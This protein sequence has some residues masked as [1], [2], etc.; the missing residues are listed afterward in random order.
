MTLRL[1]HEQES[2]DPN[3][4]H[5]QLLQT[6]LKVDYENQDAVRAIH[7]QYKFNKFMVGKWL[8]NLVLPE[9]LKQYSKSIMAS[10]WDISHTNHAVGFS[11]TKDSHFLF[12]LY[13]VWSE[14]KSDSIRATDG[15]M[16]SLVTRFT[17]EV[18]LV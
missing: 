10:A 17:T 16:I 2:P 1:I 9:D 13:S 6:L 5:F 7:E 18:L 15:Q 8:K 11:G 4:P 3:N 14:C 12:P